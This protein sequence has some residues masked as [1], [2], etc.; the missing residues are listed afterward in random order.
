MGEEWFEQAPKEHQTKI[1]VHELGHANDGDQPHS[2]KY[3]DT[4]I[5]IGT[6]AIHNTLL[7]KAS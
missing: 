5:H 6:E 7:D 2:G 3:I 1:I 4:L